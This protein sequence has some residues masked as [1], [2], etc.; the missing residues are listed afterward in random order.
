VRETLE[1]AIPKIAYTKPQNLHLTLKFLGEVEPKRLDSITESI[2]S[3]RTT[4]IELQPSGIECFPR[5]G[6]IRIIAAGMDGTLPPL[7][8]LVDAIEQ[9]CKYLGFEREQRQYKPHATLGRAR[10][11]LSAKFRATVEEVTATCWPGPR[12]DVPQFVLMKSDLDP[13]G[14]KYTPVATFAIGDGRAD[15]AIE[16]GAENAP[17][18]NQKFS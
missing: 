2:G 11:V 13:Q 10:P 3:I 14:A 9:R 1:N 8:A 15:R 16:D 12:F 17:D 18:S 5:R 6:P 7:R 4:P